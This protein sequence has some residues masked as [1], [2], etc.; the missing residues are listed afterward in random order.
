MPQKERRVETFRKLSETI[1][2]DRVIWRFDP[3]ILTDR[4]SCETI[5]ER[6]S[7]LGDKLQGLTSK[8][9]FSFVDIA[10][11]RKVKSNMSQLPL[12]ACADVANCEPTAEQQLQIAR[13][14]AALRDGW[15]S[16]GW[17]LKVATCAEVAELDELGIEHNR[18]ID[19]ELMEKAFS[20]DRILMNYLDGFRCEDSD[21]QADMFTPDEERK[22]GFNWSKLK[23]RGQRRECGCA[24]SKDIGMYNTCPHKCVYCYAN[25][26]LTMVD[27][28]RGKYAEDAESIIPFRK[29]T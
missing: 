28:N 29:Q 7:A 9:V 15:K 3:I 2:A 21:G 18:C 22:T 12:L 19:P 13:G 4:I 27:T 23:D 10:S 24:E 5:L 11:Y 16:R 20:H 1:G 26:N 14:I 17:D 25:P 6:I 8:L